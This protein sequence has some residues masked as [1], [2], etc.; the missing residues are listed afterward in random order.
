MEVK[1]VPLSGSPCQTNNFY[2][3]QLKIE[4]DIIAQC[5]VFSKGNRTYPA[6]LYYELMKVM[7]LSSQQ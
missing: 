6:C 3:C 2:M 5:N 1:I 7:T 4:Y